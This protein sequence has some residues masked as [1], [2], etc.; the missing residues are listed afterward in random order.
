MKIRHGASVTSISWIP[1]EAMTGV[2]TVPM[3]LGISHYDA[4]PPDVVDDL[5]ALRDG[6]R[7]RFANRLSAWIEVADNGEITDAGYDGGGMIGAT[8]LRLGGGAVTIPAV[9]FPDIRH[10]PVI[11]AEHVTF[12]QTAGGRTGAPMPRRVDRPPFVQVTAPTAWT[13]LQ[14]TIAIDGSSGFQLIGASPFP[15]H[16]VYDNE[17]R[18]ALKSGLTDYTK[19][20]REYFGD[21]SPWGDVDSPAIV[22]KVETALEREL[23]F[24]IMREDARPEIQRIGP[25]DVLIRQGDKGDDLYLVLDGILTVEIDGTVVAEIGPGAVVGEMSALQGGIRTATI[26]ATTPV[27]V[28]ATT[29]GALDPDKLKRLA[30]VHEREQ[31]D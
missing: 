26:T 7:F 29:A 19:W 30:A 21:N 10:D 4:P 13:T 25:G 9:A 31:P 6:D 18:L 3:S 22:A 15:R 17:G 23:S 2:M 27:R 1:S 20:S 11:T 12:T 16:W 28:A 8:T 14:L 24:Q 5:S